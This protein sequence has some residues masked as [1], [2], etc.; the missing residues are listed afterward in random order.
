MNKNVQSL[1]DL[2][3]LRC[4]LYCR[5]STEEESQ[6]NALAMQVNIS[7]EKARQ[8]GLTVTEEYVESVSGTRTENR[9]EYTRMMKD[10][11]LNK[12]DVIVIKCEDRL[13]RNEM[14][15]FIFQQKLIENHKTLYMWLSNTIYNTDKD[16]FITGIK[17]IMNRE[18]SKNLSVK[19]HAA[20]KFRQLNHTAL[21]FPSG[22]Y[23]WTKI[24]KVTYEID[25]E[26]A[27]FIRMAVQ[28]LL[29]GASLHRIAQELNEKGA[30]GLNGGYMYPCN[31]KAILRSERLY[32]TVVSNKY[33]V[34]FDTHKKVEMPR[35]QWIVWDNALP[36]I[37]D[38]E[39]W[40]RVQEV[41]D[42]KEEKS[43]SGWKHTG[44]YP[45]SGKLHC[46]LC[47]S[48]MHRQK[49]YRDIQTTN[50]SKQYTDIIWVCSN[51]QRFGVIGHEN[52]CSMQLVNEKL[53][54]PDLVETA[55]EYFGQLFT[56]K[57]SIIELSLEIISKVFKVMGNGE[58][59]KILREKIDKLK[60]QKARLL[61]KLLDET[62]S[63]ESFK[64]KDSELDDKIA[65]LQAHVD[66]LEQNNSSLIESEKKLKEVKTLLETSDIID[67]A[68]AEVVIDLIDNIHLGENSMLYI[69]FDKTKVY[70][71]LGVTMSP[72]LINEVDRLIME[73]R[74]N[75][76]EV[77]RKRVDG[78]AMKLFG[79]VKKYP[80]WSYEQY[81]VALG[82]T[83]EKVSSRFR[84]LRN[85]GYCARDKRSSPWTI[86]KND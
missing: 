43:H 69:E 72:S 12:W 79:V 75:G 39:T 86:L 7:R 81:A 31:W 82:W 27:K 3:G 62:I 22:I 67:F 37:I 25:E 38:K 14:D 64:Q 5:C 17:A 35:D 19:G 56:G 70:N 52:S 71:M 63:D 33:Q 36:A 23:G 4:C 1:D 57:D 41:L 48:V 51:R 15:W 45:L 44:R 42:M 9:T 84:V 83:K 53:L 65:S 8:L 55:K 46:G 73:M 32:G 21:N 34:D 16:R 2:K 59:P 50:T 13:N 49:Y 68:N 18:F 60:R 20:H 10:M 66:A 74:Y 11:T 47:G 76:W 77:Q 54:Y 24:D 6:V 26:Q 80:D 61:D 58:S 40:D 28:L 78:E 29:Q 30:V 85:K